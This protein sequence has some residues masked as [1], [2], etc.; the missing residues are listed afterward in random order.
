MTMIENIARAI[1]AEDGND[2]D[3]IPRHKGHRSEIRRKTGAWPMT[4][5]MQ[6]DYLDMARAAIDAMEAYHREAG[7]A[8][9]PVVATDAMIE[10]G[11]QSD[12]GVSTGEGTAVVSLIYRAMIAAHTKGK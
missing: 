2:F 5:R 9:V 3:E 4:D 10:A 12:S 6:C 8:V 1:A 7:Y 11:E